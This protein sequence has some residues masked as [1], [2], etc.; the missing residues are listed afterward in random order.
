[1]AGGAFWLAGLNITLAF[2]ANR[3]TLPFMLGVSLVLAGLLEL[4]PLNIRQ[5]I[6]VVMIGLASGRQAIW[7]DAFRRDWTTQKAM[8]WQLNWRAPDIKT[9]TIVLLNEGQ[10][11]FYADNS[12]TGALNW[13]YD[14]HNRSNTMDYLLFYPTSRLGGSL[15]LLE[16]GQSVSYDFISEEFNGNTSQTLAFYYQP[17]GCLRLLDPVIDPDNHFLPDESLMR[18]SSSLSSSASISNDP[19]GLVPDIYYPEP[20]HGWCYYFEQADL[21]GQMGDWDRVVKLG[22]DAFNLTDYPNDP[23][24]RFVFIEGY[25]S[26]GNWERA[27]ELAVQ[28]FKVSP[29][30]VGPLLC[31]LLY[32]IDHEL[33]YNDLKESS[34]NDLNTQFSCLP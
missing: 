6:V 21:A 2:P 23:V 17:P 29:N 20:T 16:K 33:P 14:P 34:L 10:F 12:L 19:V 24:E 9:D 22:D 1:M 31:K 15:P 5:G 25:S 7:G 32:R 30:Y 8:F 26:V 11:Q 13:I 27:K 4:I 3:F 18:E 28:S